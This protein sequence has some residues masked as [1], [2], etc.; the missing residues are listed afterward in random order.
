M[1]ASHD[2]PGSPA[3]P[4]APRILLVQTDT[5][6]TA[7][8]TGMIHECLAE[9]TL[10]HA[11]DGDRAAKEAAAADPDLVMMDLALEKPDPFETTRILRR[12]VAGRY[13]PV[14]GLGTGGAQPDWDTY[15]R[16][17]MNGV[18]ATPRDRD[19]LGVVLDKWLFTRTPPALEQY[20]DMEVLGV[21]AG[22]DKEFERELLEMAVEGVGESLARLHQ[23]AL[24]DDLAGIR[25]MAH[26]LKGTASAVGFSEMARL[27]ARLEKMQDDPEGTA[28]LVTG[29]EGEFAVIT[30]ILGAL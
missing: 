22:H 5:A 9:V 18:I 2:S 24:E 30:R 23:S 6:E 10:D 14:I 8:I 12:I 27:A 26:K 19:A 4:R 25:S 1:D 20:V 17:G 28:G 11:V 15:R 29:L 16:A 3:S 7:L 13:L 21:S